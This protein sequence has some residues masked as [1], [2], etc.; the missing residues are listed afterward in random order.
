MQLLVSVA[1]A[2]EGRAALLGGADV[3]DAKDPRQGALGAVRPEVLRELR[4][5][6]GAARPLSAALGDAG[7]PLLVECRARAAARLGATFV[8]VG[9][10]GA[11]TVSQAHRRAA[12]ARRGAGERTRVVLVA[13]ADW[14]RANSLGPGP[15]LELAVEIGAAGV[16]LDTMA[17][18]AGMFMLLDPT[19]VGDWVAAAHAAGRRGAQE[20]GVE[21]LGWVASRR[22]D[23]DDGPGA[24]HAGEPG[25]DT[26]ARDFPAVGERV[27]R[28]DPAVRREDGQ[29]A[30]LARGG[31]LRLLLHEHR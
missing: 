29:A 21:G 12:A 13:Y 23:Q 9:F 5:A 7:P 8:K 26:V 17:K 1:D 20:E 19:T 14:P 22:F 11:A 31:D 24:E 25:G 18:D 27:G 16:L 15:L 2:S 28:P 6:V 30:R 10:R 4:A 3:I